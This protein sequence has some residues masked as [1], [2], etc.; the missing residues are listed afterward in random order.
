MLQ[1]FSFLSPTYNSLESF[2]EALSLV[3][4]INFDHARVIKASNFLYLDSLQVTLLNATAMAGQPYPIHEKIFLL[5]STPS[6]GQ[7]LSGGRTRWTRR[8]FSS[9]QL[10]MVAANFAKSE[11]FLYDQFDSS[12][13]LL[14]I[15]FLCCQVR[16][17]G[18]SC[19]SSSLRWFQ[20][21][22]CSPIT[23]SHSL[24]C[25]EAPPPPNWL[26]PGLVLVVLPGPLPELEVGELSAAWH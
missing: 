7:Y 19:L 24:S 12:W 11:C 22:T 4:H 6:L 26:D 14:A 17:E 1:F 3:V 18:V 25:L 5:L 10:K 13:R 2:N 21:V 23:S 8:M 20:V 16:R 9:S 15:D